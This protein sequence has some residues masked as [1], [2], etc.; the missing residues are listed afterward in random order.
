MLLQVEAIAAT[1]L[2]Y[3]G[4]LD[5]TKALQEATKKGD[6]RAL[7]VLFEEQKRQ[8][9]SPR[10]DTSASSRQRTA[11][12]SEA[13]KALGRTLEEEASGDNCEGGSLQEGDL[14][15]R[16]KQRL[17]QE[18]TVPIEEVSNHMAWTH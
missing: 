16:V 4:H 8:L 13:W 12:I 17:R 11:E 6:V 5:L 1:S 14:L 7:R 15:E 9:R 10:L 3:D 2:P 18:G